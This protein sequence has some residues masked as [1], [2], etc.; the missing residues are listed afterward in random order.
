MA[1]LLTVLS[2]P[3]RL[4]C[5]TPPYTLYAWVTVAL[6]FVVMMVSLVL[7]YAFPLSAAERAAWL[8]GSLTAV[9][10]AAGL[11][12]YADLPRRGKDV[13]DCDLRPRGRQTAALAGGGLQWVG[14]VPGQGPA[15]GASKTGLAN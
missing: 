11:L 13:A 5:G 7:V 2:W 14:G 8:T 4:L 3:A 12:I 1:I 9:H 10:V 6:L 15:V